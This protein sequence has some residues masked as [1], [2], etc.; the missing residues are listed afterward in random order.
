M[1]GVPTVHLVEPGGHGGVFHHTLALAAA[2]DRAGVAVVVHT[3]ADADD[4]APGVGRHACFWRFA[5][6]RPRGVRRAAVVVAWTAVGVPSCG[7]RFRPGDVVHV[8]G[9]FVPALLE[10]VLAAARL[11]GC[12]VVYSP[13]TTFARGRRPGGEAAVRRMAR[14]AD[15]VVVFSEYD[16]LRV[17]AWG[18]TDVVG[19]DLVMT[20]GAAD[21]GAVAAWRARWG[22]A[23]VALFAGQVRPDKGLDLLVR[24]AAE[25]GV[26]VAV[27]GE[28]HGGL[29]AALARAG[30]LGV[31]VHLDEGYVATDRFV[32]AVAAAD[33]V[34]CPYRQASQSGVLA[35]AASLGARTVA[36]GVG[37][38]AEL[39][40]E[41]ATPEDPAAL[42]AAIGRALAADR[43]PAPPAG[44]DPIGPY[45]AAYG[46]VRPVAVG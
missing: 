29:S 27:V 21:P 33:V 7:A 2:L 26:A 1:R 11:R 46:L 32:A 34:V 22:G 9:R 10:P 24:A 41:V 28:D 23:T 37:G 39:A 18:V 45:L 12:R 42:A 8:E 6:V 5:S 31:A 14:S 38:L 19:A 43:R 35:L 30:Q 20:D 25:A 44:S 36:T 40:N 4:G 16:R 3:A 17:E 13:H 15:R